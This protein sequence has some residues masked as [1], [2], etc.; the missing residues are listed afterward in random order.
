MA[1]RNRIVEE[2]EFDYPDFTLADEPTPEVLGRSQ[3]QQENNQW[4]KNLPRLKQDSVGQAGGQLVRGALELS[5]TALLTDLVSL[6]TRYGAK[7]I[8]PEFYAQEKEY[9]I[10]HGEPIPEEGEFYKGAAKA[11]KYHPTSKTL[12]DPLAYV[13]GLEEKPTGAAKDIKSLGEYLSLMRGGTLGQTLSKAAGLTLGEKLT[14][15]VLGE[16]A[17]DAYKFIAPLAVKGGEPLATG[18]QPNNGR[19]TLRVALENDPERLALYRYGTQTG[20]TED[21]LTP[22]LQPDW[23]IALLGRPARK[24]AAMR[25]Q[26]NQGRERIGENYERLRR[27]PGVLSPADQGDLFDDI[28]REWADLNSTN[29]TSNDTNAVIAATEQALNNV[30]NRP[31]TIEQLINTYQNL[32]AIPNWNAAHD[33]RRR[34]R[35]LNEIFQRAIER[36]DPRI[37]REFRLTNQLYQRN[38]QIRAR[39]GLGRNIEQW[40]T[41][42]EIAEFMRSVAYGMIDGDLTEAGAIMGV[43]A[44]R[45]LATQMITNPNLQGIHRNMM[46]ALNTGDPTVIRS[47]FLK[48]EPYLREYLLKEQLD[49]FDYPDFILEE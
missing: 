39:T 17:R 46:R 40:A 22:L 23:K 14:A 32:N 26:L 44:A 21:Q 35:A 8:L 34:L 6:A 7:A 16:D 31:Q 13:S 12:L 25:E 2:P 1:P 20:L 48:L 42:A 36:Q 43:E 28:W 38:M 33:G 45:R 27:R 3:S 4:Y 37:G 11:E 10:E 5:P 47:S 15:Y 29:V 24:T 30:A 41:G 19:T 18:R 9:A 49:Q